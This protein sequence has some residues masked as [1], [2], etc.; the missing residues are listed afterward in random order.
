L[1]VSTIVT[2]T[3]APK[4]ECPLENPEITP[5]FPLCN[6]SGNC[7][8]VGSDEVLSYLNSG[9]TRNKVVPIAS[10][11]GIE[12]MID[13]T[14]DGIQ[15]LV[16]RSYVTYHV[17]G[18]KENNHE[19]LFQT[20]PYVFSSKLQDVVDLNENRIPELIF[21]SF[22]RYGFAEVDIVE[23]DG[24]K[25]RSLI[26]MG[27]D[28]YTGKVIDVVPATEYH[29]LIDINGDNLKEIVIVYN[30]NELCYGMGGLNFCDGT[31]AREQITTLAWNGQNYVAL[32]QETYSSPQFRFQAIQDGDQQA[33][34]GN[35]T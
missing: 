21:Y 17:I 12:K 4:A 10:R 8:L 33:R 5:N 25:F 15:E 14:G 11:S 9:G 18:C 24:N 34:D 6:H 16:M 2:V 1:D 19:I 7:K 22:S 29:E 23:W 20:D 13:I 28:R 3:P 35:Y 31:P 27:I 32:K 26:D 30:V